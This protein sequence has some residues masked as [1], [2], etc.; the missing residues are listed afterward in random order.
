M[1]NL[2]Q[3]TLQELISQPHTCTCGRVHQVPLQFVRVGQGAVEA[4][5]EA[6]KTI[7]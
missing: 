1:A 6:L 5:P 2:D 7:G 3:M 4:L